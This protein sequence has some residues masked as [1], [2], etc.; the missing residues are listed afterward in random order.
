MNVK[1]SIICVVGLGYVGLPLAV[2]FSHKFKVIAFD[3][4]ASRINELSNNF[5]RTN[6]V[7]KPRLEAA[8]K[9]R[10]ILTA[11][12]ADIVA[13]NVFIV[14]VPTPIDSSNQ[15]D[16]SPLR[17]ASELVG[18]SMAKGSVVIYESTVFPGATEDICVPL[19]SEF[20]GLTLNIDFGVGYSPERINPGDR[21]NTLPNIVKITSGS[22]E[23]TSIFVD[24]LYGSIIKA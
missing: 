3:I 22:D 14:T 23:K 11:D 16:L 15:P 18:R 21:K 12:A 7:S 20:S 4:D 8:L 10:L 6:E 24:E 5:D 17:G 19:L 9:E 13:A 2:E 1:D